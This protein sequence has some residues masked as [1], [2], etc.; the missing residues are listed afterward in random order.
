MLDYK[1][2]T[3][4]DVRVLHGTEILKMKGLDKLSSND[5]DLVIRLFIGYLNG[6]GCNNRQDVPTKV[7]KLSD[8]KFKI[9][10]SDGMYSYF[11]SNGTIGW[12]KGCDSNWIEQK[13]GLK[14][15]KILIFNYAHI[16][17]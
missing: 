14:I 10:F 17:I 12:L 7:E 6:C 8:D 5:S 16:K 3:I 9:Y 1:L 15:I 2:K 4:D 13:P 11:Y